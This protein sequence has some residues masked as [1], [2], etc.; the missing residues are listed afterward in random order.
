VVPQ[1]VGLDLSYL[2]HGVRYHVSREMCHYIVARNKQFAAIQGIVQ[3]P[4]CLIAMRMVNQIL[5]GFRVIG[6][7]KYDISISLIT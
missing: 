1:V 7:L 2:R 3:R 5:A 4:A 6:R